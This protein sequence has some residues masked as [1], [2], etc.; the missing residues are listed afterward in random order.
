MVLCGSISRAE[1][2]K[3]LRY[4][5]PATSFRSAYAYDNVLYMVAGQLIEAVMGDVGELRARARARACWNEH[6]DE[7]QRPSLRD[8]QSRPATRPAGSRRGT[9]PQQLLDERD[10]L[11]RAGAP[12]GGLAISANDMT[13]WLALQLR[14]ASCR[15]VSVCSAR[16]RTHR[17]GSRRCCSRSAR[18]RNRS[19]WPSRCSRH[20]RWGGASGTIAAPR[21]L[22]RRRGARLPERRHADSIEEHRHRHRDQQRRRRDRAGAD[23][24]AA[25]SLPR[26]QSQ[27]LAREIFCFQAGAARRRPPGAG[28][29][30]GEACQGRTFTAAG[31]LRRHV[32]GSA[33]R[34]HR[35]GGSRRRTDDRLQAHAAHGGHSAALAVRHVRYATRRQ[36]DRAGLRDLRVWTRKGRS[37]ASR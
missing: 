2:V 10:E 7:R 36:D 11:G 6:V 29:A 25:G 28:R 17:C 37:S 12:A 21:Y 23:V 15:A 14:A 30:G 33:V 27:R 8:R 20:M 31:A 3:R 24:R 4:I 13:K 35:A 16:R 34:Q 18:C 1:A 26:L 32:C 5:K 22:A 19:S 9:G